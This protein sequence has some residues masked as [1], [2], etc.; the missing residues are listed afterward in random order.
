MQ[1]HRPAAAAAT[2]LLERDQEQDAIRHALEDAAQGSGRLCVS[3]GRA[4]VG[5]SALLRS[6]RASAADAG[7]A[8][9]SARGGELE[10]SFAF[11][12]VLQLFEGAV[13]TAAPDGLFAGPAA[14]ARPLLEGSSAGMEGEEVTLLHALYWLCANLAERTPLLLAIEDLQWVDTPSLLFLAYL[15]QRLESPPVL[16]VGT[17]R[18]TEGLDEAGLVARLADHPATTFLELA[19]LSREGV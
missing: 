4:G 17:L 16:A 5:K 19:P 12:V 6:V 10:R 1:T 18:R 15:A 8:V 7:M 14:H 11:G 13:R 3:E 9:L 2:P